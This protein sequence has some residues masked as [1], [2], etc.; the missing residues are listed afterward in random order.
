MTFRWFTVLC[1]IA[2]AHSIGFGQNMLTIPVPRV[3]QSNGGVLMTTSPSVSAMLSAVVGQRVIGVATSRNS[4]DT[5][6]SKALLGF[7]V[8][9]D[10]ILSVDDT[11]S[12]NGTTVADGGSL[13]VWPNPS[14]EAVRM[15]MKRGDFDQASADVYSLDGG[16]VAIL[17]QPLMSDDAVEF[18]WD[19]NDFAMEPTASGTYTVYIVA[20]NSLTG[21]RTSFAASISRVR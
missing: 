21:K 12:S 5:A 18:V 7:F 15:R 9:I 14:R 13:W 10:I 6:D 19:G 2:I 11:D 3:L 8:P 4:T 20:S 16:L 1:T 17:N